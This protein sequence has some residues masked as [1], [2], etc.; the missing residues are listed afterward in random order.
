MYSILIIRLSAIG[1][2][3]M[4]SALIDAL[5]RAHPQARLT[6]LVQPEAADLLNANPDLDEVL[7]WPRGEWRRLWRKGRLLALARRVLDMRRALRSRRFDLA[8]DAQGLLKSGIWARVS[9]APRRVG[10]G[11]REGSARL[12]SEVVERGG[13][14]R[15]IGSEYLFLA[16]HLGLPTDGFRMHLALTDADRRYARALLARHGLRDAYAVI[17]PFTTRPQK[18]WV[19]ERWAALADR[20]E[21]EL[22]L[23]T[24]MLGGPGDGEAA[25]RITAA[26]GRRLVNA[27]GLTRLRQAGALIE[28]ARLL[29][30]V[31]T[32]L[33]HMGIAF[34]TP[35][36]LLFGSTLPYTDTTRA[37]ARVIHHPLPCSPCRRSPTCDGAYTC[38]RSI[39]LGE[40]LEAAQSVIAAHGPRR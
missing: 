20:L 14:R 33:S 40:I 5:R 16:R 27:A 11:S 24:V 12:M 15:R 3:V 28:G 36:V 18:H 34:G 30:G 17:C 10:L 1:D 26:A 23:R 21:R 37:D 38:M 32:G 29:V 6:W 4:A 2:V 31:D 22:G 9:G 19:E 7:V 25:A 35:S 13:D 39:E 8:I